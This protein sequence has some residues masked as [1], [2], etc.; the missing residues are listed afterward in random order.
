VLSLDSNTHP[1]LQLLHPHAQYSE[2]LT[3]RRACI[4]GTIV[5]NWRAVNTV[6]FIAHTNPFYLKG[7]V[8]TKAFQEE[9]FQVPL[10]LLFFECSLTSIDRTNLYGVRYIT[11]V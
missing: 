7:R 10:Q 3:L 9:A 4:C 8:K 1:A 11:P 2:L 5:Q 6:G